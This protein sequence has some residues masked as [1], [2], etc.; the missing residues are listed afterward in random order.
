MASGKSKNGKGIDIPQRIVEQATRL[1][2]ARGFVGAS[3]RDIAVAVGIRKP[4]LLY[5]FSS[6]DELRRKVLE[7]MLGRWNEVLPR[8][9]VAATSGPEQFDA[10]VNETIN[11]FRDDP[12]RARLILREILDHPEEMKPLLEQHVLPWAQIVANYIRKGQEAGRVLPDVDPEAYIFNMIHLL[13]AGIASHDGIAALLD[14]ESKGAEVFERHIKEMVRVAKA[15]LFMPR[16]PQSL[17]D[18]EASKA[19]REGEQTSE[20][21]IS[22][23][24]DKSAAE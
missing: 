11:F 5:H 8:L 3:L 12:D 22:G 17:R 20:S 24:G 4:S 19:L 9:L 18:G 14:N 21:S 1:F 16:P 23:S 6:K 15:S 7:E 13:V 2:A 10:V